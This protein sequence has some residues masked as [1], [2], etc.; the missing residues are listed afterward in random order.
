MFDSQWIM[1]LYFHLYT[2]RPRIPCH[3]TPG[4]VWMTTN[5]SIVLIWVADSW[6]DQTRLPR[7]I[8]TKFITLLSWYRARC[9]VTWNS[10][11]LCISNGHQANSN[12][13]SQLTS[14]ILRHHSCNDKIKAKDTRQGIY[15]TILRSPKIKKN[16]LYWNYLII[17]LLNFSTSLIPRTLKLWF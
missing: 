17:L 15:R 12:S 3:A 4:S 5:V 11:S 13:D 8:H 7:L 1:T 14:E 9:S 10:G 6:P 2:E 16:D